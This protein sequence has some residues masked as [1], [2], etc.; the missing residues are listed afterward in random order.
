MQTD[1]LRQLQCQVYSKAQR[2]GYM[3]SEKID[4]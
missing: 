3:I 2:Q 1:P 4:N